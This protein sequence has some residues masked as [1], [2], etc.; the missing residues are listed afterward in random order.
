MRDSLRDSHADSKHP[1]LV[2]KSHSKMLGFFFFLVLGV[3]VSSP[4][5]V[6]VSPKNGSCAEVMTGKFCLW[7]GGATGLAGS[8][9]GPWSGLSQAPVRCRR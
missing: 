3:L 6:V 4:T 5:M 2:Y 8:C 7:H 9:G 1:L